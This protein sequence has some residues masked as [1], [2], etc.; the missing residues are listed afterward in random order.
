MKSIYPYKLT[1]KFISQDKISSGLVVYFILLSKFK[2]NFSIGPLITDKYGE[3]KLTRDIIIQHI[4]NSKADYPMDYEGALDD[5]IGIEVKVDSIYKIKNR[6]N[7]LREFYPSEAAK[8]EILVENSLNG[9]YIN[10]QS[11]YYFPIR[12]SKIE[13]KL[14][15]S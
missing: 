13:I 15:K 14:Q 6:I 3:I 5:C 7:R 2:N 10:N 1:F 12:N 11:R 8:L 9:Q 4:E